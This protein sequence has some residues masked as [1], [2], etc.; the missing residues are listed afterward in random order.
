MTR[1]LTFL[2]CRPILLVALLLGA[3]VNLR[4]QGPKPTTVALAPRIDTASASYLQSE[5][6]RHDAQSGF[7][8]LTLGTNALMSRVVLADHARHS[9]DLQTYIFENDATGR[10]LARHL[11]AAAD[12]GVRVRLLVDQVRGSIDLFEAL[13][14][15]PNIEVRLFNPF[16]SRQPGLLSKIL[17]FAVD[18]RRLNRRMHNKSMITD[19]VTAIVGGRNIGDEYFNAG[20]D[21][22]FRDLDLVLIGAIVRATSRT[23][24][25]YWNAD[26]AVPLARFDTRHRSAPDLDALRLAL[27]RDERSFNASDYAQIVQEELPDGATADRRGDWF[28]GDATLVADTPRKVDG[29]DDPH[30]LRIG[31]Q[32]ES[33]LRGAQ[34]DIVLITP[35]FVPGPDGTRLLCDLARRGISVRILTNSLASTDEPAVHAGYAR[36][37]HALVEAGVTLHELR[38]GSAE[39]HV[40]GKGTSS[41]VSLHAKAFVVDGRTVFVGSLNM[42]QRSKLLNTEMG[43]IVDA[44]AL[45][46]A[47]TGFFDSA[48]APGNAYRLV[49]EPRTGGRGR[50]RWLDGERAGVASPDREPEAVARRRLEVMLVRLLPV[51]GLL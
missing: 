39:Q 32:V 51:E 34:H 13:D 43:V 5:V 25:A 14:A 20:S 19:N 28:W 50:L 49:L 40:S 21:T 36:Y 27:V 29:I 24:D 46:A 11:L 41:G 35:Y 42:D 18:G 31:P 37:R 47:V 26:A 8:L 17:Q 23:F 30:P 38:P 15:H 44:P 3:C 12:R 33:A 48:T 10:L 16:A 6:V 4:P 45:A 2:G 9:I 7:R 22:R 1:P